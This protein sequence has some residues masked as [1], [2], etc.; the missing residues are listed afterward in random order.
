MGFSMTKVFS[1]GAGS[2]KRCRSCLAIDRLKNSSLY[3][4]S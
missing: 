2:G 3:V 1:I 4:F